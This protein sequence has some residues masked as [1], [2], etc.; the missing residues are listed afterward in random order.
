MVVFSVALCNWMTCAYATESPFPENKDALREMC[1]STHADAD[2]ESKRKAYF[3]WLSSPTTCLPL[4]FQVESKG[5]PADFLE[6]G[7]SKGDVERRLTRLGF[8]LAH[9]H[10]QSSWFNTQECGDGSYEIFTFIRP[11][12]ENE[13]HYLSVFMAFHGEVL[14][15]GECKYG[16]VKSPKFYRYVHDTVSLNRVDINKLSTKLGISGSDTL[17]SAVE[18][19]SAN[20]WTKTSKAKP[21]CHSYDFKK[22]LKMD[23]DFYTITFGRHDGS[24]PVVL[25]RIVAQFELNCNDVNEPDVKG[26]QELKVKL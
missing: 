19:F 9:E 13:F 18:K 6:V 25:M 22:I 12:E 3:S 5:S 8:F 1:F 11:E 20:G 14:H 10:H 17:E 24:N 2:D 23:E 16:F 21:K 15:D 4:G 26:F 7:M